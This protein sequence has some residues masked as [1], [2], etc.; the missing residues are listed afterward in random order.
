MLTS[1]TSR[2]SIYF[3]DLLTEI[4]DEPNGAWDR[5]VMVE[6]LIPKTTRLQRCAPRTAVPQ[7]CVE[8]D[9]LLVSHFFYLT[10]SFATPALWRPGPSG[11]CLQDP[12]AV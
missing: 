2:Y 6:H 8:L 12:K 7:A 11:N 10:L 1:P 3:P 9:A 4:G 5:G